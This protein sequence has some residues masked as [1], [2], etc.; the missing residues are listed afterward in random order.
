MI[1]S[2]V[3]KWILKKII[4]FNGNNVLNYELNV[5][6]CTLELIEKALYCYLY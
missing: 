3:K 2:L 1:P 5:I 6:F 4:Y